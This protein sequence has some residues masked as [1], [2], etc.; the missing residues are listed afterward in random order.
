MKNRP[1][2]TALRWWLPM[3]VACVLCTS[4]REDYYLDEKEPTWLGESI[5]EFLDEEG[6]YTY[7]VRL[8]DD[9][10]YTEVLSKTGSKTL[11]VVDDATFE[12][13]FANNAWGVSSY[14]ELSDSH[15]KLL[16]NSS[17]L[18]NVYFSD[19]LGYASG[20][21][22]GR[23]IRRTSAVSVYDDLYKMPGS[24]LPE[25]PY[26]DNFRADGMV[27]LKDNTPAPL[28][29]F[30]HD[31]LVAN[32][33]TP[34]DYIIITGQDSAYVYDKSDVFVNGVRIAEP[35]LKCKN[36]VVHRMERLITPLTNMAEVVTTD[37][38]V[39]RFSQ[40]M[41]RFAAPYYSRSASLDYQ[42]LYGGTDSVYVKKYLA[43]HGH[44]TGLSGNYITSTTSG[45][46]ISAPA[47]TLVDSYLKFD[48][49]WNTFT[50]SNIV[51]MNQDMG[52]MFVP[53]DE[54][55]KAYWNGGGGEFLKDRF[56]TWE[57]VPN[58]VIDDFV[59]NHMKPS[60]V[61]SVPSKFGQ[62]KNDGQVEMGIEKDDVVRSILCCN[63]V[64]FI[65]NRVFPPVSYVAVSAPTLVNENMKIMRWAIE[66]YGF[67][68]YLLSMDSYYSF[69]LPTDDAF[70]SYI[71]PLSVAKGEP[72]LWEFYYDEKGKRVKAR[73]YEYDM[74]S[75]VKGAEKST[76]PTVAQ[77]DDRLEDIIDYHIIV[78]TIDLC[79]DGK[80][81]Y[82]NKANGT[83][84]VDVSQQGGYDVYGGY[85]IENEQPIH[86]TVD[87]IKDQTKEGNGKTYIVPN[88]M[89]TSLQSAYSAITAQA[90]DE[91][92]P[93]PFYEFHKLMGES[94]A[95]YVDEDF[96]SFGQTIEAFNTYH[97][98]IYIPSNEAVRE[99]ID[100]GLPTME[101]AEEFI[102]T[103]EE[104]YAFDEDDYRDSIRAIIADFVNYHIQD[105]S[106]YVGG[107]HNVGNYETSTL[108]V[109]T[110][111]FCRLSVVGTNSDL[112][113]TDGSS[114][115]QKVLTENPALYNIMTR[116]YLFDDSD[117]QQSKLIE[118]SS[119]A[120]IHHVKDALY[121]HENQVEGYKE[122]VKRL[123]EEFSINE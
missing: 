25:S 15:K 123:Q 51:A 7:F 26:W 46:Q 6:T 23:T 119:F 53:S 11:F 91:A 44:N 33:F 85:Q 42:R 112:T 114:N 8:I 24:A 64:V 104:N 117:I 109:E 37:S 76:A 21:L 97:Y 90:G 40:L 54:A 111:T 67:D 43:T 61:A 65:T 32:N 5:Y 39:T 94:G 13:F 88:V 14:D 71:D 47:D 2:K 4:C 68:A 34:E 57:N 1:K 41:N 45:V 89:M 118:T 121:H 3:M 62:V 80:I 18:N 98:T 20:R 27:L 59:N 116:D 115:A 103:Q 86:V 74:A 78:D 12:A 105:N 30:T 55:L 35:N 16:L 56:G 36:G 52:V 108:D 92:N 17:M 70:K 113:V 38:T 82:R 95:F 9:L 72:E 63:G 29:N 110:G 83:V 120:V 66:Q 77:V 10:D 69:I 87:N 107:G 58:Y 84:R 122:K 106:V 19:M 99:A 101:Q 49:G 50:S 96:A 48:P 102:L 73:A 93:G 79:H 60:F 75:G 28:V 81:Y 22:E 100:A 31:Y